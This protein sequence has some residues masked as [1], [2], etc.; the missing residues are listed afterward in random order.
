MPEACVSSLVDVHS[1]VTPEQSTI[2]RGFCS[3]LNKS[4][5]KKHEPSLFRY[6]LY[7][8]LKYSYFQ[9]VNSIITHDC[10]TY[11]SL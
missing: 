10:N 2:S 3:N 8:S 6:T 11:S 9:R 1:S 7:V 5:L 4:T